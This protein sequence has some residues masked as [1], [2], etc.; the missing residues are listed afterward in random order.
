MPFERGLAKK[1]TRLWFASAATRYPV[2]ASDAFAPSL[3]NASEIGA[4]MVRAVASVTIETKSAW[5]MTRS[6][7]S[8]AVLPD[9]NGA[10]KRRIRELNVSATY[11]FPAESIARDE[12][13]LS[14]CALGVV[15]LF[16]G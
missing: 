15:R 16:E 2:F 10:G 9:A 5:P 6:A 11:R 12:G 13:L 3:V 4:L 1:S 7:V 14:P 8:S